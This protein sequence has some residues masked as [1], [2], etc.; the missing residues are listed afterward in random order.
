M[1]LVKAGNIKFYYEDQIESLFEE[2][3]FEINLKSRIGLIGR[4]GCGKTTLFSLI[5]RLNKPVEGSMY[6]TPKLITGYLP[7]EVRIPKEMVV[8]DF[9]WQLKPQLY[10]LK[11]KIEKA[12]QYSQQEMIE[13]LTDFDLLGG[14]KFDVHFQK[15]MSQFNLDESFLVRKVSTLSG[16]EKTK[17][18]FC[19]IVL[20]EPDLL[21]L[22][23]PTNHLDLITL[24]WLEDY[25]N[26]ISI[27][28]VV[29]SHDRKFLDNCVS[30]V[31]ELKDKSITRYSGNY[32]SYKIQI[33][34]EF[35]RKLHQYQS[36]NK[37]IR[38]LQKA[39]SERK[40][41][42]KSHQGQ[43]GN[44]GYAPVY[45]SIV[46]TAKDAMR[47]AKSVETRLNKEI[48]KAETEKPWIEKKRDI[49]FENVELNVRTVLTVENLRKA[50]GEKLVLDKLN[51]AVDT[52]SKIQ[53]S[54]K[55]GSGKSTLFKIIMQKISDYDGTINWSPQAR[56]GYYAQ[57]IE[58]L[59]TAKSII[60]E[61]LANDMSRQ[62]QAR[63][64]LGSLNLRGDKVNQK[65]ADLSIG[66]RSKVALA[67]LIISDAN[68][69]VLDEPT[70][71]L[72][73]EAREALEE[74]LIAFNG[75]IIFVS[76]DRYLCE[77]LATGEINLDR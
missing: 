57:E 67:K 19:R 73:I 61:L 25:L 3:D 55:N 22:D 46:N 37:R 38:K 54:G 7:Q 30:E 65:I 21:L 33:D 63:T 72:E 8:Q 28:F 15:V 27:P 70:N 51:F 64:V 10:E 47:R 62:S 12:E 14:Y 11:K 40:G 43:T 1:T 71:H 56:V 66:E 36:A 17:I 16:G 76:H 49:T 58:E 32:S 23:E 52:G 41:W 34:E 2:L 60:N 26:E 29:I 35:N 24:E 18:A 42:A 50:F 6:I 20:G 9:L 4:N 31:W 68:V 74:A 45:E 77:K 69:L 75:T 59:D 5:Q 39:V 48:K 13:N 53:V 44:E